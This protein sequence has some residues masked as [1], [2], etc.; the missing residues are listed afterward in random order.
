M[1]WK[2]LKVRRRIIN[3][4]ASPWFHIVLFVT[5]VLQFFVLPAWFVVAFVYGGY[6]AT[7]MLTLL[8]LGMVG[9]SALYSKL[10]FDMIKRVESAHGKRFVRFIYEY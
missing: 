4:H 7:V 6:A 2:K 8:L 1:T 5:L 3:R 9:G 10:W